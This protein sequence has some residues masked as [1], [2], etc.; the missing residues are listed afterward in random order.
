MGFYLKSV[1]YLSS[2]L[3]CAVTLISE[4]YR[5]DQPSKEHQENISFLLTQSIWESHSLHLPQVEQL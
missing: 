2:T 3:C 4:G 5:I 1:R